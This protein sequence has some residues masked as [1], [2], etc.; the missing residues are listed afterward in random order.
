MNIL[1]WLN[2]ATCVGLLAGS[3]LVT[4]P[5]ANA[6]P[7]SDRQPFDIRRFEELSS[8]S[9]VERTRRGLAFLREEVANPSPTVS[10]YIGSIDHD[11]RLATMTQL[12]VE[13]QPDA[14]T[15]KA[16][17]QQL[18]AGEL[19]NVVMVALGLL[20]E[21]R[22]A[23]PIAGIFA[24][25]ATPPY[26][27]VLAG[28]ALEVVP[29]AGAVPSVAM[30]LARDTTTILQ[31]KH[32]RGTNEVVGRVHRFL[33]REAALKVLRA[34]DRAGINLAQDVRQLMESAVLEVPAPA[35]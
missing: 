25:S 20:G 26:Q 23:G 9:P 4:Q 22:L 28:R 30:V 1:R 19:R 15:L 5:A 3:A 14:A 16:E 34:Q 7:A 13:H 32:D 12:F 2:V 33:I 18:S 21:Q 11:S 24:N 27:R 8:L 6:E 31:T 35:R 29:D 17:L 10:G